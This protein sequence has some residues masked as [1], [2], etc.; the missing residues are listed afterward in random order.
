MI[1][2]RQVSVDVPVSSRMTNDQT[3]KKTYI[4]PSGL[5]IPDKGTNQTKERVG[6]S[7]YIL[8]RA[9]TFR[10]LSKKKGKR[11]AVILTVGMVLR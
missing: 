4:V 7:K 8:C 1:R 11:R 9:E 6:K 2:L 5:T 3:I 10:S